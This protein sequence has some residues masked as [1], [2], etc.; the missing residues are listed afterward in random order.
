[1]SSP[2]GLSPPRGGTL[3]EQPCGRNHFQKT[4]LFFCGRTYFPLL[5]FPPFSLFPFFPFPLLPFPSFSLFPFF[6]F[7]IFPFFPFPL[8]PF[9]PFP[10][11][12]AVTCPAWL[13][14]AWLG[15]AWPGLARLGSAWLGSARLGLACLC[16]L[17]CRVG[18]GTPP[19]AVRRQVDR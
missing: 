16:S 11:F 7:P 5:P 6:P 12:W 14:L 13:G 17:P 18:L 1:M 8:F 9:F 4:S 19:P 3:P 10:L 2:G 15:L